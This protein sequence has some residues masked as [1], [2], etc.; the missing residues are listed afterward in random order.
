MRIQMKSQI[1]LQDYS[2]W[3]LV[4]VNIMCLLQV[5]LLVREGGQYWAHV[6]PTHGF[7]C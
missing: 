4:C 1:F 7:Y 5:C 6:P 3:F 2:Q